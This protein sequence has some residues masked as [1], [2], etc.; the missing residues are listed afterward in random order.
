MIFLPQWKELPELELYLDQV[1]LYVNQQT[2]FSIS[3]KEKPLT[4]SMVNN[5]VKQGYLPKPIKKKYGR[6]HLARLIVLTICKPV[7]PIV[8]IHDTIEK[9][10]SQH[11]AAILYD[12]FVN[13]LSNPNYTDLP[14]ITKACQTL[15]SYKETIAIADQLTGE[16]HERTN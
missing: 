4:A 5:Y 12:Y 16:R 9:L 14:L 1:L 15:H 13:T 10:K 8:A 2:S 6:N 7:F 11:E 3:H